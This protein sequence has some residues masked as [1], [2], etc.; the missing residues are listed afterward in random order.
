MMAS[1]GIV[2]IGRNEGERLRRCLASLRAEPVPL[3]YVDSCSRDGSAA[4]ARSQGVDVLELDGSRPLSAARARNEGFAHLLARQPHL[5]FVQFVDGDCELCP[6]WLQR[7]VEALSAQA[8]LGAVCGRVRERDPEASI[9]N[10]LCNLEWQRQPGLIQAC[11]GNFMARVAAFR[12][13]GGFDNEIM[14]AED[15]EFCL[16]LRRSGWKI[17]AIDADMVWHD[18]ALLHFRQW[19]MRS[20]RAGL[21]YAQG[22]ALHGS[23]PDRHFQRECRSIWFWGL[24][25][26]GASLLLSAPTLGLSLAGLLG[27]PVLG[28]RV[29][30]RGRD[31]GWSQRAA[32]LYACFTILGKSSELLGM[33]QYHYRTRWQKRDVTLIEPKG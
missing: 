27:Y 26:P 22:A 4:W 24:G 21:A 12:A 10:L 6:G 15:N 31:R 8:E 14:A 3:V 2:V 1:H 29:Y 7:G 11:G 16:R 33:L 30:R 23:S 9:Y 18:A 19:W 25:L 28:M 17:L 32:S 20:R 5:D 13:V